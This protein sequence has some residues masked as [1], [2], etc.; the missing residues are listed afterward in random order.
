[1]TNATSN[2]AWTV[3]SSASS[4]THLEQLPFS[5]PNPG[6]RQVLVRLTAASLN[7]R[8]L[9]VATRS[10]QYPGIDGLPGNHKPA[11]VPCCDGAGL[12]HTAGP[13]SKWAGNV[14]TKVLLHPN[15]WLSGDVRNLDL[16]QVYGASNSDGALNPLKFVTRSSIV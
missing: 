8:D 13:E 12:I 9:L 1:M 3:P 4:P 6:P 15:E 2:Q 16:T 7:Y 5:V 10:P 14:G 11:L